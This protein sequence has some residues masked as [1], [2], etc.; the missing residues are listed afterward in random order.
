MI[1]R[2]EFLTSGERA[3]MTSDAA[4]L[5]NDTDVGIAITYRDYQSATF[6]PSTGFSTPTY[7]SYAIQA[8][9]NALPAGEVRASNGLYQ[10][11]DIRLTLARSTLPITPN[12]KDLI[13]LGGS[14]YNL[15]NWDSDPLNLL[16]RIVARQVT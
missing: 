8:I 3:L 16:W 11:G 6:T 10:M 14:T 15:V 12:T 9:Q 13:V 4:T 1:E 7:T 5:V 2:L